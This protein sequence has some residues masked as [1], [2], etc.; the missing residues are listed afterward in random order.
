MTSFHCNAKLRANLLIFIFFLIRSSNRSRFHMIWIFE[1]VQRYESPFIHP[2]RSKAKTI[3]CLDMNCEWADISR[4]GSKLWSP[5][6][7]KKEAK[8]IGSPRVNCCLQFVLLQHKSSSGHCFLFAVAVPKKRREK[9]QNNMGQK[10]TFHFVGAFLQHYGANR[11]VKKYVARVLPHALC[12]SK[13]SGEWVSLYMSLLPYFEKLTLAETEIKKV[14]TLNF[15]PNK[16]LHKQ[17]RDAQRVKE[18]ADCGKTPEEN[19]ERSSKSE[20]EKEE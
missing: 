9:Q 15:R 3:K 6:K 11:S 13:E 14:M 20:K 8:R 17:M 18:K 19:N 12:A 7:R 1:K 10:S 4:F 2:L 5:V 16:T